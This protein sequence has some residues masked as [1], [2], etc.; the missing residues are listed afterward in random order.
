[1]KIYYLGEKPGN[2]TTGGIKYTKEVLE[3]V[4]GR[5]KLSYLCPKD[6]S[7]FKGF[8]YSLKIRSVYAA[9]RINLWAICQLVKPKN[10]EIIITNAYYRHVFILFILIARFINRYK[11]ITFVNAIYFYSRGSKLLNFIDKILMFTFLSFS[12]LII[13]NSKSTKNE[14]IKLGINEEKI[15][16]IYPRL[17][18][19]GELNMVKCNKEKETFEILFVGYCEPFKEVDVLIRAF[20]LCRHLPI[21][22]HIVGYNSIVHPEYA[23]KLNSLIQEFGI[24]NR[25]KFHGRLEGKELVRMYASADLFVSPGSGE[26]FGRVLIE[27]MYYGLPVIGARRGASQE[28]IDNGMNG[29]LFSPGDHEDLKDKICL[30]YEN[31]ELRGSM[32]NEGKKRSSIANFS[33]DIGKQFHKIL[34]SEGLLV[35]Y[36]ET[37]ND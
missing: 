18:L 4:G 33:N 20:G 23:E 26:G 9:I 36:L 17:D 19:P 30:L 24:E 7:F 28:L 13:A 12:S 11:V 25:V 32:G 31:K 10:N 8:K 14:L 6:N 27:A 5:L 16:I 1:M 22:L 29:F 21:M 3:Y 15:K 37:V 34:I 2:I 35:N